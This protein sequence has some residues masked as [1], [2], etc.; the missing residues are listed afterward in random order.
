MDNWFI[1]FQQFIYWA[2]LLVFA[3]LVIQAIV[4]LIQF[5]FSALELRCQYRSFFEGDLWELLTGDI[6]LPVSIL[7]PAYNEQ[8]TIVEN[9]RSLISLHYP[10]FEV[11]VIN[12]GSKDGTLEEIIKALKLKPIE[13]VYEVVAPHKRIRGL[14]GSPRYPRLLVVDK[15]NGGKSDALNAGI[16]ISRCPLFCAVDADSILDPDSLLR[17]V[18]PFLR[19]PE[20]SIA[21]GGRIR[22]AN[23]CVVRAGQVLEQRLPGA[24]LPMFQTIEYTR[25]FLIARLAWSRLKSMLIISGAFGLFKRDAAL[26]VGGYSHNTVGEDMEIVVKLHR[27]FAEKKMPYSVVYVPDPVCWTEVPTSLK[28]LRRQRTRWQRGLLETMFKH[29][30]MVFSPPYGMAGLFGMTNF[31]VID[32]IGPLIESLGYLLVVIA[33]AGGVLGLNFF[34]AY[35]GLTFVFGIFLSVGSMF[36]EEFTT[37]HTKRPSDLLRLLAGAI[38]ENFGYRQI[39]NLWRLEGTWHFLNKKKGWGAM[40]RAGFHRPTTKS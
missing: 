5:M 20:K 21:V 29:K 12:D 39:N 7:V 19:N 11:I 17:V 35:L 38:A 4:Y 37:G 22:V 36:L 10:N 32:V 30:R 33:L 16:N 14:Y 23:G 15:E 6:S 8:A 40:T 18:R 13:R 3:F 28:I 25:A 26:L 31:F 1:Y 27:Y 24:F 34:L 9:V 2:N